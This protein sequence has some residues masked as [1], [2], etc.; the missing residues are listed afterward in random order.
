[1]LE[2]LAVLVALRLLLPTCEQLIILAPVARADNMISLTL[3][4]KMRP[5]TP[6]LAIIAREMAV[7]LTSYSFLPAVYHTPGVAN[8]IPDLLSRISDPAKPEARR[9]LDHPALKHSTYSIAPP[10]TRAFYKA[11]VTESPAAQ[12]E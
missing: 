10:R 5:S 2:A 6:E 8:V 3:A 12:V 1:M 7:C 9:V 4:M 11:L